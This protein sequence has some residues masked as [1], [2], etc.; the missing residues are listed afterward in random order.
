MLNFEEYPRRCK[1]RAFLRGYLV[2]VGDRAT[3][4]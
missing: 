3:D 1:R 4:W 2:L